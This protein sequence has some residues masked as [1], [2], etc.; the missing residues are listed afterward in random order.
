M[1]KLYLYRIH[2]HFCNFFSSYLTTQVQA[3][4]VE[5]E[6]AK[7]ETNNIKSKIFQLSETNF[8]FLVSLE[9]YHE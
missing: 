8:S 9:K 4:N 7:T 1:S 3:Q 6:K 2:S 5:I